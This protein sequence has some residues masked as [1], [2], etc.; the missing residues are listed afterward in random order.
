MEDVAKHPRLMRR[1]AVYWFRAKVPVELLAA[2]SPKK[3]ITFSLRTKDHKEALVRVRIESVKLDQE[4]AALR[5]NEAA[6]L[7]TSISEAEI[8]RLA[9][10]HY[11]IMLDEDEE[12][13]VFGSGDKAVFGQALEVV[14]ADG[15]TTP[16][17]PEQLQSDCG[18]SEREFVKTCESVDLVLEDARL[19]LA[20]GDTSLL[21]F[22]INDLLDSNGIQLSS[23]SKD[24]R[25][26]SLAILKA[27]VRAL[28]ALKARN[29]GQAIDTPPEPAPPTKIEGVGLQP[30]GTPLVSLAFEKWKA[31]HKGPAKTADEFQAQISRFISLHGDLPI[32]QITKAHVRCVSACKF[33]PLSRGIGVQN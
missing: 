17:T 2:Y 29:E 30:D 33:D 9:A 26:L 8:E 11:H 31:E 32:G 25:K 4:F 10:L 6:A 19:R 15:G 14:A 22:E 20:R 5:A 12:T 13:R 28:E 27:H 23:G 18:L 24:R 1:G 3:E 16:W 21:E 7:R